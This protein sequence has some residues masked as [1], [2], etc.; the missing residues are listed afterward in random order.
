MTVKYLHNAGQGLQGAATG[1]IIAAKMCQGGTVP[2]VSRRPCFFTN[3]HFEP[4]RLP[5]GGFW[6]H[7]VT[8]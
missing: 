3:T 7:N 1:K 2:G 6:G 8:L 5:E 4:F